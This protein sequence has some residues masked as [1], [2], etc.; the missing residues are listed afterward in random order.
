MSFG[1]CRQKIPP[2]SPSFRLRIPSKSHA[3][4]LGSDILP[5]LRAFWLVEKTYVNLVLSSNIKKRQNLDLGIKKTYFLSKP[6]KSRRPHCL[7]VYRHCKPTWEN[8]E[9]DLPAF[10]RSILHTF[11]SYVLIEYC[12]LEYGLPM[13]NNCSLL[14]MGPQLIHLLSSD[15]SP[16]CDRDWDPGVTGIDLC[17]SVRQLKEENNSA[18]IPRHIEQVFLL[19]AALAI[20]MYC[21]VFLYC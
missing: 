6:Y 8:H 1:K 10:S 13:W 17:Y 20:Q 7:W 9:N 3:T 12:V 16:Y 2:D 18:A 4:S 14:A 15:Y 19:C 21:L 5:L 11:V